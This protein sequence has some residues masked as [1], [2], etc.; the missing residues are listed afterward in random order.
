MNTTEAPQSQAPARDSAADSEFV[1]TVNDNLTIIQRR[2]GLTLGTDALL[3]AAYV[4]PAKHATAAELGGGT[5]IVSLLLAV[6]GKIRRIH[7]IEIQAEYARLIEQN[8]ALNHLA[9]RVFA[10]HADIRR[11]TPADLGGEVDVVI[12]N[13][14]YMC[15]D[16]GKPNESAEKNIARHEIF[17][18][19]YD[20]CA[21]GARLLKY[22]GLFY[23]VY[24]PDRLADLI[25]ACRQNKLEPKRATLVHPDT[26]S[27]PSLV[28]LEAKK[29]GAPSLR[30]TPPLVIYK[31]GTRE[32][33]EQMRRVYD[34]GNL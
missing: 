4:R 8:A 27:P 25:D 18:S 33:S 17:G 1:C 2:D 9:D 21:S 24:R 5:G 28:L 20:F 26:A 15:A 12:T 6:R 3:L 32:Y 11:V 31:D 30:I 14:P 10:R 29:A 34:T 23:C 7:A 22:G 16:T 13:P 19:I